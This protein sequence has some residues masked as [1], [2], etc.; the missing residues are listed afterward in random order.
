MELIVILILIVFNGCFALYEIALVSSRKVR[1]ETRARAGSKSARMVLKQLKEPE[2]TLSAI[3]IV[4]TLIGILSGAYGGLT[5][6]K[7]L[8]S[9]FLQVDI[10]VAYA[11]ELSMFL[12]VLFITY[13]SLIIGELVP[14][15]IAL[16]NPERYATRMA[17]TMSFI[18]RFLYPIVLLLSSSTRAVNRLLGVKSENNTHLTEEELR[19]TLLQGGESGVLD[20]SETEMLKD[21]FQFSDKKAH[22]LMT[23]RKEIVCID[24]STSRQEVIA[25]VEKAHFSKYPLINGSLDR[26]IGVVSV[27]DLLL[28]VAGSQSTTLNLKSIATEPLY[29]PDL[30]TA[31]KV[32]TLFKER[33]QKFGLVVNEYGDIEGIITLHDLSESLMGSIPEET[34]EIEEPDI[35]VR[36]DGSFLVEGSMSLMDFM[37]EMQLFSYDDLRDKDFTTLGGM[38]MYLT[39]H[40]PTSGEVF[41]YQNLRFEVI[42]MDNGRVDKLLVYKTPIEEN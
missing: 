25:L 19:M 15:S 33:K 32:L 24:K 35:I 42:D 22:E 34:D 14:K 4:I 3:Q 41:T 6:S 23:H 28:L 31:E 36:A 26:I 8:E 40:I 1:L 18:T 9:L 30:L 2:K 38:A 5:L 13:L 37:D 39:G 16:S 17:L 29:V 11:H 10:L 27:K 7:Y 21:V 20:K 12:I